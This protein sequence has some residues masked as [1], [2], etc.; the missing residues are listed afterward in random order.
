[1]R[2]G[3][4]VVRS[5]R[6]LL[7]GSSSLEVVR[8]SEG[9]FDRALDMMLAHEDKRWGLTDCTSF[10]LMRELEVRNAFTFDHNFVEAG[11]RVVP[12]R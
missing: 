6:G 3:T 9:D 1:M 10:V 5:L 2:L 11:F 7:R 8:V 4:P 12:E